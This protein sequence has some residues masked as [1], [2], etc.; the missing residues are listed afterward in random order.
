MKICPNCGRQAQDADTFCLKCGTTLANQPAPDKES[1]FC[2]NCGERL[3]P[4][5]AF[6]VNCGTPVH[7][8]STPQAPSPS[9]VQTA[10]KPPVDPKARK[11]KITIGIVAAAAVAAVVAGVLVIP[12]LF[13]SPAK[14]F[15]S[16]QQELFLDRAL[17]AFEEGVDT[18]GTG[19][20][21]S[22]L[23]ITANTDSSV[24]N[25][26]LRDSSIGLKLDLD[27]NSFQAD[28]S[29]TLM[30]SPILSGYLSYDQGRASF[31]LPEIQD[32]YYTLDLSDTIRTVSGQEVDLSGLTLPQLSGKEWR[33]LI[34]SY[35]DLVCAVVTEENVTVDKDVFFYLSH[36]GEECKG[37]RYR[38]QPKAEDVERMLRTLAQSLREDD[39]LRELILKVVNPDMLTEAFGPDIFQGYDLE[40]QL[41]DALLSL[42][43]ELERYAADIGRQV[44]E[45]GFTWDLYLEGG[46]VRMIQLYT[47][48]SDSVV[49]Y[50]CLGREADGREEAFYVTAY[51]ETQLSVNHTYTKKG[52]ASN[53]TLD[54]T[55]PYGNVFSL[56]Y[57]MDTGKKS[58]LSIP[59]GSFRIYSDQ[60]SG[61][62]SLEVADTGRGSVEHTLRLQIDPSYVGGTF[63]SL[64]VAIDATETSSVKAPA[65]LPQDISSYSYDEYGALFQELGDA[66]YQDLIRNLEPLIYSSYGW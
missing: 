3:P 40:A 62:L 53:G 36:L 32:T 44:E 35:L 52:T 23:T 18:F 51:G 7:Q 60:I 42:A 11:R 58:P 46:E 20:F 28:A 26:Y 49:A 34:Q 1:I 47:S 30:G 33:S 61:S 50:E 6:C 25:E 38:F 65:V 16:R 43:D 64:T 14:Q 41:D 27:Q 13:Q 21:S 5:S 37:T 45:S 2:I 22:D 10:E 63:G 4:D 66:V 57:D 48:Q 12:S 9:K 29:L 19:Q 56:S 31:Y 54:V 8:V 17:A 24:I 59:Q 39:N 55:V 15:V